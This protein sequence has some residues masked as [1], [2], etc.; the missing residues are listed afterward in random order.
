MSQAFFK[1]FYVAEQHL[2]RLSLSQVLKARDCWKSYNLPYVRADGTKGQ[3][4]NLIV[5]M[6]SLVR[7]DAQKR[8]RMM[9]L[10]AS[11]EFDGCD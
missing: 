5:G 9:R 7:A 2:A 10:F 6:A 11:C 3:C 1:G 4:T 8:L